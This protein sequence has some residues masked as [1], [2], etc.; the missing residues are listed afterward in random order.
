MR[1][2]HGLF[3]LLILDLMLP[4]TN[5]LDVCRLLRN[6][7]KT[8]NLPIIMLTAKGTEP[9][10][11]V[12]LE[13]GADDYITKPFSIRELLARVKSVLRRIEI[14][15]FESELKI[16]NITVYPEKYIAEV[17]GKKV[18]LTSTEFKILE[19]LLR[20]KERVLT[21]MQ[22]LDSLG[23]DRQFVVDRTVDVH[24]VNL[25]KKLGKAG[26]VIRTIRS[27]GYKIT[28]E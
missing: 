7:D 25:R 5:G 15:E 24:I 22:I 10:I 16:G 9:D 19:L 26:G 21:R 17:K 14:T 23:E 1:K 8:K 20:K 4:G 3:D 27:V 11:V 13:L 28:E 12:G 2:N 6:D 18:D